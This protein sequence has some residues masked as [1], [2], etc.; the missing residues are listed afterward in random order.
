MRLQKFHRARRQEVHD[1]RDN[2]G[3][4]VG[5]QLQ[6]ADHAQMARSFGMHAQRL[7]NIQDLPQAI[8][9][10]LANVPAL[11]DVVVSPG[12]RSSDG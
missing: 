5:T 2:H 4:V 10:A 7:E 11:L 6:F 8:T 12:A 9:T 1:Q 3:K